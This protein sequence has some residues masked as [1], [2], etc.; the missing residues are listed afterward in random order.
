MGGGRDALPAARSTC[1]TAIPA[2]SRCSITPV[3]ADQLE[4]PGAL[5][6][7]LRF[8]REIR[9]A[10]HAAL[11]LPD[12]PQLEYSAARY[13]DAADALERR[14]D[15]IAA[16]APA[17]ELDL[18]RHPRGPAAAGHGRRRAPAGGDR[19]SPPTASASAPG[20]VASG[21]PSARTRR[22][23]T[24]CSRR[25][26]STS[27]AWTGPTSA[28]AT[29]AGPR[30]DIAL[31]PLDRHGDRPRLGPP[32]L[33]VA[34]R[35]PGHEPAHRALRTRR[36]RSTAPPTTPSAATPARARTPSVS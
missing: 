17:R 15:L 25:P 26:A 8:L 20:T 28:C 12:H 6:R 33:P 2:R 9:P 11:D 23:S 36:G 7:R 22:G 14:G 5:E 21:C 24:T 32:G 29:R 13:E 16:F 27:R 3:L 18:R 1:S 35:L 34:R 10:S 30:P 4:A 31:V 19:A